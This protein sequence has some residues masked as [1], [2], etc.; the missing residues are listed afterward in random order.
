MVGEGERRAVC[1]GVTVR[2]RVRGAVVLRVW[3]V[4]GDGEREKM[5][6]AEA[7]LVAEGVC[8]D[9]VGVR[10]TVPVRVGVGS[11][12]RLP[13][14]VGEG[15]G[16]VQDGLSEAE[17]LP[18]GV[19][20]GVGLGGVTLGLRVGLDVTEGGL[21]ESALDLVG[22]VAVS[23]KGTVP[24]GEWEG[25]LKEGVGLWVA[26]A[27]GGVKVAEGV[28]VPERVREGVGDAL[29]LM[30]IRR[31]AVRLGV[32][33]K[34]P[35]GGVPKV[36][37]TLG[38][39]VAGL[40]VIVGLRL[41]VRERLGVVPRLIESV[42]D[43]VG[44]LEWVPLGVLETLR[45]GDPVWVGLRGIVGDGEADNESLAEGRVKVDEYD[46]ERN[47]DWEAVGVP[48]GVAV[49]RADSE[50]LRLRLCVTVRVDGEHVVDAEGEQLAL[51]ALWL[52][53]RLQVGLRRAVGLRLR[54]SEGALGDVVQ[55]AERVEA[56]Q[57]L[58]RVRVEGVREEEAV[59]LRDPEGDA[60]PLTEAVWLRLT[61][62]S[63]P[64][65]DLEREARV[66]DGV[67]KEV[68]L[69]VRVG[70]VWLRV[71]YSETRTERVKVRLRLKEGEQLRVGLWVPV[72]LKLGVLPVREPCVTLREG[73]LVG[74]S[75]VADA[76][77]RDGE[78]E[79]DS[80]RLLL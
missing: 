47:L 42:K 44:D 61:V 63:V 21:G 26:E 24:E 79:P 72:P 9:W 48:V 32:P 4:E 5:A 56:V 20:D 23:V 53:L 3:V 73:D 36:G 17:G 75:G 39:G 74:E 35:E 80:V 45:V 67:R 38:V 50:G 11:G 40:G 65:R 68:G 7:L 71:G 19:N 18:V 70:G 34:D 52:M 43:E 66:T 16:G 54:E 6:V 49:T 22:G 77:L 64:E 10:N 31:E 46:G 25:G 1:E 76:V 12:V 2:E 55:E 58:D 15:G 8:G 28:D 13:V 51:V 78:R 33:V 59:Q 69:R 62:D 57:L 30:E 37:V 29:G 60:V 27:E 41:R 14:A